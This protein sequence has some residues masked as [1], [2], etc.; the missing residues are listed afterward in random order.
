VNESEPERATHQA[1]HHGYAP[2]L[3]AAPLVYTHDEHLGGTPDS[4]PATRWARFLARLVDNLAFA[5]GAFPGGVWFWLE[6]RGAPSTGRFE[7]PAV[8]MGIGVLAIVVI[9]SV[10]VTRQ[11]QSLGKK[12]LKIRVVRSD[13]AP[14]DFVSGVVL[15]EWAPFVIG[16][17]PGLGRFFALA[18]AVAIFGQQQRCLHDH[19]AKTKVIAVMPGDESGERRAAEGA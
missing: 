1:V 11:G 9:Q 15:R 2:T 7:L 17:I 10:L 6:S 14:V 16:M 5:A 12:L 4:V 8:L 18:D 13:G 19:M 3:G